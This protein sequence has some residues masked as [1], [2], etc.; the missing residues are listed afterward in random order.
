MRQKMLHL[1]VLDFMEYIK[2]DYH[3][4]KHIKTHKRD[5]KCPIA[6]CKS[7]GFYRVRD[8][9]RHISSCHRDATTER[10]QYF[11]EFAGCKYTKGFPRK[12][13]YQRHMRLHDNIAK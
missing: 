5:V 2:A 13:N 10:G 12:D 4:S 6:G 3:Y 1:F 9:Y 7:D 8:L 11:C